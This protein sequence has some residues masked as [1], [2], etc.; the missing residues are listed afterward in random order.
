MVGLGIVN[1]GEPM[2][3]PSLGLKYQKERQETYESGEAVDAQGFGDCESLAFRY[4]QAFKK[5]KIPCFLVRKYVGGKTNHWYLYIFIEGAWTYFD[6][7]VVHGMR[8]LLPKKYLATKNERAM[9]DLQTNPAENLGETDAGKK[10]E[11]PLDSKSY[12]MIVGSVATGAAALGNPAIGA[13]IQALGGAVK[14]VAGLITDDKNRRIARAQAI[15]ARKKAK[16]KGKP[17]KAIPVPPAPPKTKAYDRDPEA[18]AKKLNERGLETTPK[19]A[20]IAQDAWAIVI[21]AAKGNKDAQ[22]QVGAAFVGDPVELESIDYAIRL[23]VLSDPAIGLTKGE[24]CCHLC[25]IGE[26]HEPKKRP[27][28][29]SK[30]ESR[31]RKNTGA[32]T[33]D[34]GYCPTGSCGVI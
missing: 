18:V 14:G 26:K 20:E 25:A 19:Q 31:Y 15:A 29:Q 5:L 16:T 12:D 21:S 6:P 23:I 28:S 13:G 24:S 30:P 34:S 3:W 7:S 33:K 27:T 11:N 4:A 17:Y 1:G 22:R 9:I 2:D 10:A 8:P 32:K